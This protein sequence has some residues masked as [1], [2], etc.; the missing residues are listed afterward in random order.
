MSH[1]SFSYHQLLIF[2]WFAV[3]LVVMTGLVFLDGYVGAQASEID[4]PESLPEY[5]SDIIHPIIPVVWPWLSIL[6]YDFVSDDSFQ[7]YFSDETPFTAADYVPKDLL[8]IH[9]NFTANDVKK[10]KLR[11]EAWDR[12]A[13]M[14]WH[15]RSAFSGDR[16]YIAS[17]YR[18]RGLQDYLI[19]KWCA[20][21]RCAKVG[22]SEHEA[23]LAVDLKVITKWGK[24]YSLDLAYP[25]K[26][27][28]R[29]KAHAAEFGF[30]NTYQKGVEVDGK[31][32]EWRHRRYL[33]VELA[34][35][36]QEKWQTLAEY[37]KEMNNQ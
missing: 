27:Y 4:A 18:S 28:D 11:Q 25:N 15:F 23:W 36:L 16:L 13:D 14:A 33:G 5:Q 7:K 3:S 30:H 6:Q 19:Q 2:L 9:S 26:Y 1:K 35:L 34:T 12:F 29:L 24:W 10:F 8:P 20:L 17:A 32:V 37:Y 22:T 31:I 21:F